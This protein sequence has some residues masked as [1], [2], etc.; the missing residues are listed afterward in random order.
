VS[1]RK[2][3]ESNGDTPDWRLTPQQAAP[4]TDVT[5]ERDALIAWLR[6]LRP[7]PRPEVVLLTWLGQL[8]DGNPVGT[9]QPCVQPGRQPA[10]RRA[11]RP[12]DPRGVHGEL[13][14]A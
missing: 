6:Q 2:A 13:E 14:P 8:V 12:I 5:V 11:R 3:T 4:M 1:Q 9:S 10:P 7:P